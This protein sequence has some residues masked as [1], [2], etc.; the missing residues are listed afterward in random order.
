MRKLYY[1][2][3][4]SK[5]AALVV[6]A[7]LSITFNV[8][9]S[10]VKWVVNENKYIC[11]VDGERVFNTSII[12]KGEEYFI[13]EDGFMASDE[14]INDKYYSIDGSLV[15]MTEVDM[16]CNRI[17]N[18]IYNGNN[19]WNISVIDGKSVLTQLN[20]NRIFSNKR[21][22]AK[23]L[24]DESIRFIASDTTTLN[25]IKRQHRVCD[26]YLTQIITPILNQSDEDKIKYIS[27]WIK[28]KF[29]YSDTNN[30]SVYDALVSNETVCNSYAAVF[31]AMCNKVGIQCDVI[32]GTA[33]NTQAILPHAWNV[34]YLNNNM[35]YYFDICWNDCIEED[36]Y[37]FMSK[38]QIS[39][40]HFTN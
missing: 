23:E 36:R 27:D 30:H 25:E 6:A 26:D 5:L 3:R 35:E 21:I 13:K 34:L 31:K 10:D 28:E 37:Y 11:Y 33:N 38:D 16:E 7:S 4:S 15:K 29:T 12:Y 40:D 19:T 24:I 8:N 9:A 2:S 32:T 17:L 22:I 1:L 14:I 39:K 20:N 18:C